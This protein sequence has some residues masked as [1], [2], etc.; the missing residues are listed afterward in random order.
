ML[1]TVI[2]IFISG[3]FDEKKVKETFK[4]YRLNRLGSVRIFILFFWGK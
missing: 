1:K 4:H 2:Y 3:F